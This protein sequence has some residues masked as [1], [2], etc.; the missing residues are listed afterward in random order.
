MH[1]HMLINPSAYFHWYSLTHYQWEIV[2][3]FCQT[4]YYPSQQQREKADFL[5]AIIAKQM[6]KK[7]TMAISSPDDCKPQSG[8]K[9]PLAAKVRVSN[10]T[11]NS[12]SMSNKVP[13]LN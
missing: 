12:D 1:D 2:N 10:K 9:K 5:L 8:T 3:P 11:L 6:A 13:K 7:Q 4:I